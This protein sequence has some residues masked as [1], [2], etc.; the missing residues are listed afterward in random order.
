MIP[1]IKGYKK[2]IDKAKA[3]SIC[4]PKTKEGQNKNISEIFLREFDKEYRNEI[5]KMLKDGYYI[6][7]EIVN[8]TD[9]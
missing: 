2:M 3:E 7:Q 6:P 9:L 5:E 4:L 8:I 1:F